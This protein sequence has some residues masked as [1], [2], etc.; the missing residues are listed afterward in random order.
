MKKVFLLFGI[1]AFSTASAQ[2]KDVFDINRHIQG[3]LDKK[4]SSRKVIKPIV[5]NNF[6]SIGTYKPGMK[7]S[8]VLPN[9][10]KIYLLPQD[11]MPCVAPGFPQNNMPNV[12]DPDKFFES[13]IVKQNIPGNIPNVAVPPFR[14]IPQ[15]R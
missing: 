6:F 3:F 4:T 13:N 2:Q 7:L 5:A 1:A 8:Y 12:F 15:A 11:N 9:G 10:D 14:M